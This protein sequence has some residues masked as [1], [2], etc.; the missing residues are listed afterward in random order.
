MDQLDF[1]VSDSFDQED[2][3]ILTFYDQA[4]GKMSRAQLFEVTLPLFHTRFEILY[5]SLLEVESETLT[6]V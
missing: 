5:S 1:Q 3:K 6:L 4:L 2:Q